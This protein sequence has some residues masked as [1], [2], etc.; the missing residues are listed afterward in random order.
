MGEWQKPFVVQ[1]V[2]QVGLTH[3]AAMAVLGIVCEL[4]QVAYMQGYL[5]GF[6]V[7]S[8]DKSS[9]QTVAKENKPIVENDK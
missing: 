7:A 4:R 2:E 3:D 9:V 1:L 6:D 5:R 8:Q